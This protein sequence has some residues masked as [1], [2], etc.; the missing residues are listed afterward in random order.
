MENVSLIAT[1]G[2]LVYASKVNLN[3]PDAWFWSTAYG[4]GALLTLV[5]I[6]GRKNSPFY[7]ITRQVSLVGSAAFLVISLQLLIAHSKSTFQQSG[8]SGWLGILESELVREGCGSLILALSLAR[9]AI[10]LGNVKK[11]R[12]DENSSYRHQHT[13]TTDKI[14]W[15]GVT[16]TALSAIGLGI[17]IPWYFNNLGGI[18]IPVHCGGK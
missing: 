1:A 16:V 8:K 9:S 18:P 2:F 15:S 13:Y 4:M 7:S 14:L 10:R 12:D 17:F 11:V 3:D 6:N 5:S